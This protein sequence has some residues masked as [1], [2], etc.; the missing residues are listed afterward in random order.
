[1]V[2]VDVLL[3]LSAALSAFQLLPQLEDCR[4]GSPSCGS[5][6]AC[7]WRRRALRILP[8]YALANVAAAVALG[9]ADAPREAAAA[10]WI[11]FYHCPR[12]VWANFLLIQN[13]LGNKA[14]GEHATCAGMRRILAAAAP[15]LARLPTPAPHAC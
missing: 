11:H 13:F 10:R 14:C 5:V 12:N 1:M 9:P 4:R 2:W 15:S 7:Y 8:A 6:V 3:L